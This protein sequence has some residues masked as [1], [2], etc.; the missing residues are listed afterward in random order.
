MQTPL[1]SIPRSAPV[2]PSEKPV[3]RL[4]IGAMGP[5]S[6]ANPALKRLIDPSWV[7]LGD[8]PEVG[9]RHA[10]LRLKDAL[11]ARLRPLKYRLRGIEVPDLD[12]IRRRTEFRPFYYQIGD[13]LD[14]EDDAFG[15][16]LSEHF[17]EHLFL[18]EA[19]ALFAECHRVL[20]PGG[21]L[22]VS[23]PDADLRSYEAP[24]PVGYPS[25]REKWHEPDKHKTRWS[26]YSLTYVLRQVGFDARPVAW[27]D[28]FGKR[29]FSPPEPNA[30]AY[31]GVA[32]PAFVFDL[33]CLKRGDRSLVV[34]AVKPVG[35][36]PPVDAESAARRLH[37]F[38]TQQG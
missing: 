17:F 3:R 35:G 10:R 31:R 32:D 34:D 33:S 8:T 27:C 21:V 19:A 30:A 28:K 14:F 13:R 7:H 29:H 38:P 37:D 12:A 5:H 9:G 18:D 15:F 1:D 20:R 24:E 26:V 4:H 11:V 23:V 36:A 22:R 25:A 16:V 6:L 2:R